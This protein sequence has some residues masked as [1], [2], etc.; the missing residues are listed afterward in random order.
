MTEQLPSTGK[1]TPVSIA[2]AWRIAAA[3]IA[4]AHRMAFVMEC[5]VF[6]FV[7]A[8]VLAGAG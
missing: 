6:I 3:K 4:A 2:G 5:L 1:R 8:G 7:I